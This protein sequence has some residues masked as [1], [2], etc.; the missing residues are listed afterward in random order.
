MTSLWRHKAVKKLFKNVKTGLK[1][2]IFMKIVKLLWS[3][4]VLLVKMQYKNRKKSSKLG[5]SKCRY[6]DV[7]SVFSFK[8]H[9]THCSLHYVRNNT[10]KQIMITFYS[11]RDFTHIIN[12]VYQLFKNIRYTGSRFIMTGN[13]IWKST[14]TIKTPK[15]YSLRW[16][17]QNISNIF[18]ILKYL[19]SVGKILNS[20]N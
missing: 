20:R 14:V 8:S 4:V 15:N 17:F 13:E 3:Y 19:L 5:L 16:Y 9:T 10:K 18:K 1:S 11:F 12:H 7:I 6:Y 2:L